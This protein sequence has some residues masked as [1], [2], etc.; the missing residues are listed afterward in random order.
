MR[1]IPSP[2]DICLLQVNA[3]YGIQIAH[4]DNNHLRAIAGNCDAIYLQ[5]LT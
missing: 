5:G 3:G 4:P 2:K 1:N